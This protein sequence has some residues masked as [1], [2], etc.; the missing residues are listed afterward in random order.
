[1]T[2]GPWAGTVCLTVDGDVVGTLSAKKWEKTK[3]LI[4]ELK[5]MVEQ[6]GHDG[7]VSRDRLL[8]IRGFLIYVVRT[9]PYLNPY[10]KGLHNTIDGFREDRDDEGWKMTGRRLRDLLAARREND[11]EL[12]APDPEDLDAGDVI[13]PE[14]VTVQPRLLRDVRALAKLT[15]PVDPPRESMRSSNPLYGFLPGDASGSGFGAALIQDQ[16]ILYFSGAWAGKWRNESSNF[17]E[18]SNLV[19]R[20]KELIGEGVIRDQELFVFTDNFTFESCFYKGHSTSELLSDLI[21]DLYVAAQAGNVKLHVIWVAGT[22]MKAWGIDGLSRGDTTEGLMAGEDPMAFVPLALDANERSGGRVLR[23]VESFLK[24]EDA[25][26]RGVDRWWGGVPAVQ[27]TKD[28]MFELNR[29]SGTRIWILPPAAMETAIECF[30]EDRIAHPWNA[31]V[32][33]IPRLMTHLWQKNLNKDADILFPVEAGPQ[34]G[35]FWATNQHEPLIVA[36]V[37]PFAYVDGYRGPW[38]AKGLDDVRNF[39]EELRQGFLFASG[40]AR[41]PGQLSLMDSELRRVWETPVRRSRTVLQELLGWARRFP[42]V[43]KCMVRA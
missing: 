15:E 35:H 26:E 41:K 11:I 18:S 16:K 33:A 38:V 4:H 9:Y 14:L 2:P 40:K 28:N 27:V 13:P 37:F 24:E 3:A 23:W 19:I 32:F 43:R 25:T 42:P 34:P 29:V 6:A 21:L 1:M 22:R 39:G 5:D 17:R 12:E 36:F 7:V 8:S 30:N 31:H 20:L 10:L